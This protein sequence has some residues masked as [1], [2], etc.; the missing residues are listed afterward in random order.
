MFTVYVCFDVVW[1]AAKLLTR[2]AGA[3]SVDTTTP[4]KPTKCQN[5]L[6]PEHGKATAGG[7]CEEL[8]VSSCC[9]IWVTLTRLKG[10]HQTSELERPGQD[11]Q[12]EIAEVTEV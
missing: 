7:T 11:F 4:Y 8:T 9:Q 12:Q 5:V 3:G 10:R 2:R 1:V 6:E